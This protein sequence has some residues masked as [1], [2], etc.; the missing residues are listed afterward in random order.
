MARR[1]F[2][3]KLHTT[4]IGLWDCHCVPDS[5]V[6]LSPELE[7]V[8]SLDSEQVTF[9]LQVSYRDG[10]RGPFSHARY[11]YNIPDDVL[12]LLEIGPI[13]KNWTKGRTAC[14][15]CQGN[16]GRARTQARQVYSVQGC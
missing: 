2:E 7:I 8:W 5:E 15:G 11:R 13:G 9:P 3:P 10:R 16:C 14:E 6:E 12:R 4:G 1:G